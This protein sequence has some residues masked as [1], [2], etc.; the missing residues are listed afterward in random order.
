MFYSNILADGSSEE[1]Y[2]PIFELAPVSVIE[3][4]GHCLDSIEMMVAMFDYASTEKRRYQPTVPVISTTLLSSTANFRDAGNSSKANTFIEPLSRLIRFWHYAALSIKALNQYLTMKPTPI[5]SFEKIGRRSPLIRIIPCQAQGIA[6]FP[7]QFSQA[8]QQL[9][10][11]EQESTR[12]D[13]ED[14]FKEY[15]RGEILI[16]FLLTNNRKRRCCGSHHRKNYNQ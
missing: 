5:D 2:G 15:S 4:E 7:I 1:T 9:R 12:L 11:N 16:V 6:R 3:T 10:P 14:Y 8:D 13:Q